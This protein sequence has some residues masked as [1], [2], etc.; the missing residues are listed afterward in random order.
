M[1][2]RL[3]ALSGVA[4]ASAAFALGGSLSARAQDSAVPLSD[5]LVFAGA[6]TIV[7]DNAG[8]PMDPDA[9]AFVDLMGGSGTF[10]FSSAVCVGF[11]DPAGVSASELPGL[12]SVTA[13]G[14]YNN[15]VCGT[16]TADGN[17]TVAGAGDTGTTGFHIM[18]VATIGV[19]TNNGPVNITS[20]GEPADSALVGVVLLLPPTSAGDA[21]NFVNHVVL[22]GDLTD[23][24][25][26][27][28]IVAA[29][30][31]LE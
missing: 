21:T 20:D 6:A 14:S 13:N 11:S 27:F 29:A 9:P 1:L 5:I 16:G 26:G 8:V 15:T 3:F 28:T 22:G 25:S 24:T 10:A 17:A 4:L 7:T 23:C 31:A 18:F 2:R 30:A 19:V 12:C